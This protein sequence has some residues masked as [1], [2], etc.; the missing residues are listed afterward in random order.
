MGLIRK[1]R[2]HHGFHALGRIGRIGKLS[3]VDLFISLAAAMVN[4]IWAVYLYSFLQSNVAVGF[5]SALLTV[6]GFFSYFL[7]IPLMEKA[8]K[9]KIYF[10]AGIMYFISY[11]LFAINRNVYVLLGLAIITTVLIS[12]KVT[13]FGIIVRDSSEKNN[14]SKNEGIVYTFFNLAYVIG[15]LLAGYLTT[16][17]DTSIIFYVAAGFIIIGLVLFK[18]AKIEDKGGKK[19]IDKSMIKNFFDFFR[20]KDRIVAYLLGAG[21]SVWWMLIYLFVPL[22]MLESGFQ[23]FH[24]GYFMFAVAIPLILFEYLF[25][26]MTNKKGFKKMFLMG[27]I[28]LA[29]IAV[30]CFFMTN[31][32]AI[33]GLLV[34]ASCGIAMTEPTTEAYFL[35][36]LRGKE[37]YRF[38]GPYNTAL[39]VGSFIGKI[40]GSVTLIFLPFKFIF[41]VIGGIMFLLFLLSFRVRKIIEAK[42]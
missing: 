28:I 39:D 29:V 5:F 7:F 22:W 25:S 4:T 21:V 13:C 37:Q 33:L 18:S 8:D 6:V 2:S 32:L 20:S 12:I 34:L 36:I 3:G 15:P 1:H 35:D 42:R 11:L 16:Y 17:F 40:A 30:V 38:Y 41:L 24:I 27:H 10:Y 23:E 26:R 14:L 31:D 19:K 9:G